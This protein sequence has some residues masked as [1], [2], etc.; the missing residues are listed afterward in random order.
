M[1]QSDMK[2]ERIPSLAAQFIIFE[3]KILDWPH[4]EMW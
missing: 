2:C 3:K 1:F 4:W